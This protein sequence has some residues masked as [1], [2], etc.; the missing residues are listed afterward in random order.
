MASTLIDVMDRRTALLLFSPDHGL[1][2]VEAAAEI[3]GARLGWSAERR[4]DEVAAYRRFAD[5]H[6]VPAG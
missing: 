4:A 5:E 6:G 2:G 1:A 3:A